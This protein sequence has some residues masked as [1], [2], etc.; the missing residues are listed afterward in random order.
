MA[1][2][3]MNQVVRVRQLL[4]PD[5][6]LMR[7]ACLTNMRMAS[8][9]FALSSGQGKC[10]VAIVRVT[11]KRAGDVF[12]HMT[13]PATLPRPRL[14]ALRHILHP[15]TGERLD[16]GLVLW[17]PAPHSF[18]GED[19]CELHMHGGIA[20]ISAVLSALGTLPGYTPA[21]PGD[22]TKR[23]FHHGKLD[24]TAVEGL[25]DLIHA[26]TEA[27]RKQA[28]RQMEG[29]LGELYESWRK[30][31]LH[32]RA[33]LEA[34]IDFSEDDN[35]ELGVVSDVDIRVQ[36]LVEE[37]KRHLADGRRGERLRSGL[38]L[39]I[40]GQPNV[41]KSSLLNTI[42]QR[43][44]AIVSPVPGTTRDVVETVVDL[45]GYPVVVCDTAGL[46]K[47]TDV[48]EKE[49]VRR[50]LAKAQQADIAVVMLE[51]R[52]VLQAIKAGDFKWDNYLMK[53]FTQMGILGDQQNTSDSNDKMIVLEWLSSNSYVTLVNKVDLIC[54]E[55]DRRL[56]QTALADKCSL[57]SIKTE[58]GLGRAVQQVKELC[59]ALCDVGMAENPT[60]TAA[61]H[62][63]HITACLNALTS[64]LEP[65]NWSAVH[66]EN[67]KCSPQC[68]HL[69]PYNIPLQPK[70]SLT[71]EPMERQRSLLEQEGTIL[72][73]AHHLQRAATNLG[74]VT[75]HITSE[76]VLNHIFSA[77]CI[78][79]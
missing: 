9:V 23:A 52:Q 46:R 73:A 71:S 49:G 28:L 22:F 55:E 67:Y 45:G 61:R 53:H 10:G 34:Y 38:Q 26:E 18:T 35:I 16:R 17:F 29:A 62:R 6:R 30:T 75:G 70:E 77:F 51:A 15:S 2:S 31:I 42:I 72:L 5:V 4:W 56:L 27:Q 60:L 44:A 64:I 7:C 37:M 78:G 58:E 69:T 76:D 63:T 41:G 59:A 8:T 13:H 19:S 68:H 57:L 20:V 1:A 14:A 21:Q 65:D 33:S 79:K 74:H 66:Q 54:S 36:G 32:C 43:P 47:T 11:G 40:L 24:L 3:I 25:G 39:A 48:V 50:A 12:T